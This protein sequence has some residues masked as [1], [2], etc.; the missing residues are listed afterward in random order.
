[1]TFLVNIVENN[2][3]GFYSRAIKAFND[4][5]TM[6]M[7]LFNYV[8]GWFCGKI[9]I[10]SRHICILVK[11]SVAVILYQ[12][13]YRTVWIFLWLLFL[14]I[15]RCVGS[16]VV[17]TLVHFLSACL[18]FVILLGS[19][20]SPSTFC[21]WSKLCRDVILTFIANDAVLYV[22][23][24]NGPEKKPLTAALKRWLEKTYK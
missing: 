15:N 19:F 6:L 16:R 17:R 10:N 8:R 3:Y 21:R 2:V 13:C 11:F 22:P 5:T 4:A 12:T 18:F 7:F 23:P 24:P 9:L 20:Y 14:L 1:M